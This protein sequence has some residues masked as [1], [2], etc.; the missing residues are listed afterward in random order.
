MRCIDGRRSDEYATARRSIPNPAMPSGRCKHPWRLLPLVIG[1][2][3]RR[4][5]AKGYDFRLTLRRLN[6]P[7]LTICRAPNKRDGALLGLTPCPRDC[8]CECKTEE[9]LAHERGAA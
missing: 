5:L 8:K 4:V 9:T 6:G 7:G 2:C 1:D 3:S